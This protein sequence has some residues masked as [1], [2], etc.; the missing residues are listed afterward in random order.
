[1]PSPWIQAI[2]R[3][4]QHYRSIKESPQNE[5][6]REYPFQRSYVDCMGLSTNF[7]AGRISSKLVFN[8]VSISE[9]KDYFVVK[10]VRQCSEDHRFLGAQVI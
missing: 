3:I 8:A 5:I 9:A 10:S 2:A 7:T 6:Q 1:L 4:D